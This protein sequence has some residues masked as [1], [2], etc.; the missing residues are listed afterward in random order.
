MIASL[1]KPLTRPMAGPAASALALILAGALTATWTTA[2]RRE[3]QL[4]GEVAALAAR[5]EQEG[6]YFKAQLTSCRAEAAVNPGAR[7]PLEVTRVADSD[8]EAARLASQGPAGFDVCARMEAADQAVLA[9]LHP[10]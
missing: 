5:A 9:S 10:K 4:K 3:R 7:P 6:A 2:E 1:F 8:A